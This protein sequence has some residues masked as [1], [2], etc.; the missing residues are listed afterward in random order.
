MKMNR[1]MTMKTMMY[2][3][4]AA[5][6]IMQG[7]I[8]V[9]NSGIRIACTSDSTFK[10]GL[11]ADIHADL[12]REYIGMGSSDASGSLTLQLMDQ[13]SL[14][15]GSSFNHISARMQEDYNLFAF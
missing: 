13:E 12:D 8:A 7:T 6:T 4:L 15:Y 1:R 9:A 2:L 11:T 14:I 5:L 3:G 10:S